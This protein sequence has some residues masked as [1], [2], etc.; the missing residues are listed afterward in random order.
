MAG[1]PR[2]GFE[3]CLL[4]VVL[5]VV[6]LFLSD[7]W[8][9]VSEYL[10][11]EHTDRQAAGQGSRVAAVFVRFIGLSDSLSDSLKPHS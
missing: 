1:A 6:R 8:I 3:T 2:E 5:S 7:R 4:Y 11:P 9:R 10:S